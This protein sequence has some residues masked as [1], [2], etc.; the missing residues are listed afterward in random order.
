MSDQLT[1]VDQQTRDDLRVFLERLLRVG[2][3]EVRL[4]VRGSVLAVFGCTQAPQ[5]LIDPVPVVLVMRAFELGEDVAASGAPSATDAIGAVAADG[6]KID[7]ADGTR[8]DATVEAR[9][10]LDR[11]ARTREQTLL[12]PVPDTT[13]TAAWAGVLPPTSGWQPVGVFEAAR[14]AEIAGEGI[15]RVADALPEQ[16]GD[17]VVRKVRGEIWGA[18]IS[19]GVPAAAAFAAESMGFLRGESRAVLT[20]TLTWSRLATSRGQVMARKLLG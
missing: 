20:R 10:L 5:S 3:P 6:A 4:I 13:V 16:P 2:Q 17:A 9:A 1:L 19:P 15:R 7:A 8:I 14:L 18:E 11:L 12:L